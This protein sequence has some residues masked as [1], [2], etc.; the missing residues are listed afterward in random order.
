MAFL[1][2][3]CSQ[4]EPI[5]RV[6]V[7]TVDKAIFSGSWY[8][9]ST[10]IDVDYEAAGIGTYPGDKAIDYAGGSLGVIPRIRWVIDEDHLYAYRDYQ[11]TAGIDGEVV[12]PGEILGQPVAAYRIESHFDIRR[13]YNPVTGEERNVVEENSTDRRWFE[14]QYMRVDW[15]TN[16]LPAYFG[17]THDLNEVFGRFSREPAEFFVQ[18]NTRFPASWKPQFH[19]MTCDGSE[20][21][22]PDCEDADRPW[23]DDYD[24]GE[25][26]HISFVNQELLSP[27]PLTD[28]RTGEVL[29]V[30]YRSESC[31]VTSIFTRQAY[32]KVSDSPGRREE[33][34]ENYRQYE[35]VNWTDSR[36]ERHGYFRVEQPTYD[37]QTSATDPG[38]RATDFLNYNANRHNL[39][40]KW[41]DEE[42]KSIPYGE[43]AVRQVIWHTTPELP[44]HLVRSS[45][46]V[47]SNWNEVFMD[48]V[49]RVRK[50]D[51]AEYPRVACQDRD[52]DAYCYCQVDPAAEELLNADCPGIYDPFETPEQAEAR[53]AKDPYRCSIVV[54]EGAEPDMADDDVASNLT[55]ASFNGWFDAVFVGD[56]CVQ[57]LQI[58]T[59]N[60]AS[61]AENGGSTDGL[62]CE[63]RG[64]MRFKFLS[65]VDQPGTSFLGVATLRGD[66]VTG[67]ILIGDANIGGPALDSYRRRSLETYDILNGN[68]TEEELYTGEDV[69]A[70]LSN[71]NNVQLPAPP[72]TNFSVGLEHGK[73]DPTI[74]REIQNRMDSALQKA[75]KLKGPGGEAQ[76]FS[77]RLSAL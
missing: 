44:A 46:R 1:A 10:V 18:G 37:R 47:V 57:T 3:S 68:I 58:N 9:G 52:P 65:Y 17:Q 63:E 50:E 6:G 59:C 15:S 48:T 56:E 25:I 31:H 74:L 32:L 19:A 60:R 66:P 7:N 76:T 14:R 70:Y 2:A 73:A 24:K 39:W 28:P 53:G 49:R 33:G 12:Q 21:T 4:E 13:A 26:Y 75:E 29:S 36:F 45:F 16:L 72:R 35:P 51:P 34:R 67:E 40:K 27:E 23:A 38:Y 43:R 71:L 22:S 55:D 64:D 5:S 30:C 54:P 62:E 8:A 11:L 41:R 42:G 20:D 77:H 61:I 69:R